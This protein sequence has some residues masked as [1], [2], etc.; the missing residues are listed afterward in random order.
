MLWKWGKKHLQVHHS[1]LA[2][3]QLEAR[4]VN[5]I[6]GKIQYNNTANLLTLLLMT[7]VKG[8]YNLYSGQGN[9]TAL[10]AVLW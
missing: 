4:T 3:T 6:I 5:C 8:Q 7:A 9:T 10:A 2:E 1:L